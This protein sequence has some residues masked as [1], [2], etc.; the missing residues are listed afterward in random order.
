MARAK[1][2]HPFKAEKSDYGEN[3]SLQPN[4]QYHTCNSSAEGCLRRWRLLVV[5]THPDSI[6]VSILKLFGPGRNSTKIAAS[7]TIQKN[8]STYK[9]L[10]GTT[11]KNRRL[12]IG[13][14][15]NAAVQRRR[16]RPYSTQRKTPPKRG[17]LQV[18]LSK[19]KQQR[20]SL[21]F[22]ALGRPPKQTAEMARWRL[23]GIKARSD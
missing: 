21:S 10:P 14:E 2:K 13:S 3:S 16:S 9:L 23:L 7:C 8:E 11:F 19:A 18:M 12:R 5:M 4:F 20:L 1:G 22:D 15:P 17:L 6:Y